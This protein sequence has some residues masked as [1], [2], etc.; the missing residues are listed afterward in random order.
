MKY[1]TVLSIAGSD[2]SGGA[3][4]QADLKTMSA[5]GV[6]GMTA[7]TAI[8][9][10]N[11]M[12]VR[13][14]N[15]VSQ[16]MVADQIDAVFEDIFPDAVKIGMLF[17]SQIATVVAD[18]LRHWKPRFVILDPVMISTSGCK[19][20]SDDA[21]E[22]LIKELFP[23]STLVTP[24]K[25]ETEFIT[26]NKLNNDEDIKVSASRMMHLGANAVLIKGGHLSGEMAT[27]YFFENN[28]A[29]PV[30]FSSKY[31]VTKNTH[32]TGCTLSSAI[33][34]FLAL[35]FDLKQAVGKAKKYLTE[36]LNYGSKVEIGK[37]H[38]PVNHSFN[39]NKLSII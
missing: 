17:D 24:N 20:I 16:E 11:T 39:P 35:G 23:I 33:A 6:Y 29:S 34:S 2:S 5:L 4:I 27:D 7:I 36:A 25:F 12:G 38:G 28:L 31:I 10:Q 30:L 15:G 8:T 9:A 21:I 19:L 22:V 14:S 32:G 37:G 18:R 1:P 3:G 13:N 26:E